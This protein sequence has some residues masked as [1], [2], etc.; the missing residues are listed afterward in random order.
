MNNPTPFISIPD[1]SLKPDSA[2]S[3]RIEPIIRPFKPADRAGLFQ[4]AGDT[5]FFG[6]PIEAYMEDRR[7]FLDSFYAYYTDLEP[8]HA[9]VADASGEV[10]GFI[11]GCVDTA[12]QRMLTRNVI[13]PQIRRRFLRGGYRLG[14]KVFRYQLELILAGL[15]REGTEVDIQRY[16]AHLHINVA[17]A[18]RGFGLGRRLMLAYLDQLRELHVPGVHLQTTSYNLAACRLYESLGFRLVDARPNRMWKWKIAET[19]ESRAY[20]LEL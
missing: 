11:T 6:A 7:I 4:I 17:D 9:W 3:P 18:W 19:F 15:R 13:L 8:E 14:P 16:P 10:A 1:D 12:R 2:G 5:A 20:A